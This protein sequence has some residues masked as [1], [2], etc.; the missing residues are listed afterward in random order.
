PRVP[1]RTMVC[2]GREAKT[3]PVE[4][5]KPFLAHNPRTAPRVFKDAALLPHDERSET[6]NREVIEFLAN[7]S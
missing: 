5:I 4:G 2:W 7:K 3:S 6:F 1:H